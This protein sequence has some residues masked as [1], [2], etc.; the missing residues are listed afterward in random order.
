M[1]MYLENDLEYMLEGYIDMV[2][3]E[4]SEDDNDPFEVIDQQQERYDVDFEWGDDMVLSLSL[5][6]N[7]FDGVDEKISHFNVVWLSREGRGVIP[8]LPRLEMGRTCRGYRG[9]GLVLRET[10]IGRRG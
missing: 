1:A 5:F 10:S 4:D 8:R 9:R 7:E 6:C 3:F 2:G